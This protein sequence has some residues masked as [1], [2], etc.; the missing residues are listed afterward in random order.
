MRKK[1]GKKKDKRE[2]KAQPTKLITRKYSFERLAIC[3]GQRCSSFRATTWTLFALRHGRSRSKAA[4]ASCERASSLFLVLPSLFLVLP[5]VNLFNP[6]KLDLAGH[7][8]CLRFVDQIPRTC[9][10]CRE[11]CVGPGRDPDRR[12]HYRYET[13]PSCAQSHQQYRIFFKKIN[14]VESLC[15]HKQCLLVCVLHG[16]SIIWV[17]FLACE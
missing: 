17:F 2:G 16:N 14:S 15:N 11:T 1:E 12:W 9:V 7:L 13:C 4:L 6:A 8:T 3:T 5:W 10:R